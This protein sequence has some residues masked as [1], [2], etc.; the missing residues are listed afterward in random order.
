MAD[1][2]G[3]G[4]GASIY[5]YTTGSIGRA[6]GQDLRFGAGE[7]ERA[8]IDSSGNVG[9]GTTSPGAKLDVAGHVRQ[10]SRKRLT[11]TLYAFNAGSNSEYV[12]P[13]E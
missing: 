2:S 8:R 7:S 11:P 5:S 10:S 9:I 12:E 1:D 6:S 13:Y 4:V 3:E